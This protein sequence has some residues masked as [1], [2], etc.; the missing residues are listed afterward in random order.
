MDIAP[1]QEGNNSRIKAHLDTDAF[2]LPLTFRVGLA[3]DV[4]KMR[5]ARLTLA[6]DAVHPNNYSE[7]VS[8]GAEFSISDLVYL[9]GGHIFYLDDSDDQGNPYSPQGI[10]L[11][12]GVEFLVTRS[13]KFKMDV[14]YGDWGILSNVKRFSLGLEF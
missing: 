12:G 3:G 13:L 14:A 1:G 2:D 6:A 10:S 8:L 7:S 5:H 11:G 9:R 4:L